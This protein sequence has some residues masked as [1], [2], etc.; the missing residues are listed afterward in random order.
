MSVVSAIRILVERGFTMEQALLAA[1]IFEGEMPRAVDRAAEKRR[2]WDRERKRSYA[3][4]STGIPPDPPETDSTGIPPENAEIPHASARLDTTNSQI[5]KK[6][7]LSSLRSD[8]ARASERF[9]REFWPTFPNKVG[10]PVALKAF[11]SAA[12]TVD[13]A[14]IM[15]GL[16]RYIREK[17][18]DRSWLNPATF[19]N[20]RRW[21]D[22]PAAPG[23]Q[24]AKRNSGFNGQQRGHDFTLAGFGKVARDLLGDDPDSWGEPEA[25]SVGRDGLDST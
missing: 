20:Q 1:E 6:E 18:P 25:V 17:P 7:R 14:V 19:L 2:A 21:E 15:A 11:V 22:Q 9:D 3:S 10:R 8:N 12:R 24:D 4:N 13:I 23:A 5:L 16:H